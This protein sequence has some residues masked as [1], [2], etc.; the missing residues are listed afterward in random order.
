VDFEIGCV[1]VTAAA[2]VDLEVDKARTQPNLRIHQSC[3]GT[4]LYA[5]DQTVFAMDGNEISAYGTRPEKVLITCLWHE[6]QSKH[7]M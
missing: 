6:I 3:C 5:G 4:E 2:P 1:Q 7:R